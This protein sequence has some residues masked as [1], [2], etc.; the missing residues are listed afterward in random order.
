MEKSISSTEDRKEFG[1]VQ[2]GA[3][4]EQSNVTESH[5]TITH[6]DKQLNIN[7]CTSAYT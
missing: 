6:E 7:K 2:V 3:K 1:K 4:E 5:L